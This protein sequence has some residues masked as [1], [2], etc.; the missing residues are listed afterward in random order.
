MPFGTGR[1]AADFAFQTNFSNRAARRLQAD[2][3][4]ITFGSIWARTATDENTLR[5]ERAAA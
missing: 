5:R 2:F 3:R 4:H 1:R